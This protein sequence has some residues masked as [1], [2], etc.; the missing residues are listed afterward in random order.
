MSKYQFNGNRT[1]WITSNNWSHQALQCWLVLKVIFPLEGEKSN[2]KTHKHLP[3]SWTCLISKPGKFLWNL[4]EL[5]FT[6]TASVQR[7]DT[8]L[9]NALLNVPNTFLRVWLGLTIFLQ[10]QVHFMWHLFTPSCRASVQ[11]N[12]GIAWSGLV[13]ESRR[14]RSS[15]HFGY[16]SSQKTVYQQ[17]RQFLQHS[18]SQH[19]N[20]REHQQQIYLHFCI[21]AACTQHHSSEQLTFMR[22]L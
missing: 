9:M 13:C 18:M 2:S 15:E 8:V 21:K 5:S 11:I 6:Y 19:N 17:Q 20:W 3:N 7:L 10:V 14:E 1:L 16:C 12:G 4:H 22:T